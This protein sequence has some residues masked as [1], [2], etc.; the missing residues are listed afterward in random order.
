MTFEKTLEEKVR[1]LD[2]YI[3][4]K[5]LLDRQEINALFLSI[6]ASIDE[7]KKE[8][9]AHCDVLAEELDSML[10]ATNKLLK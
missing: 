5:F 7:Y 10:R 3:S 8:S 1:E 9:D 2:L 6:Y 4:N